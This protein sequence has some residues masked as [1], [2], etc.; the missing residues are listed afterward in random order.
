M[1][2]R[3]FL[4][5]SSSLTRLN[6]IHNTPHRTTARTIT[7]TMSNLADNQPSA[8]SQVISDTAKQEGGPS[9]GKSIHHHLPIDPST[10]ITTT[11]TPP[12]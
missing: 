5:L 12:D 11:T 3:R 4:K 10:S 6:N 9:K 7:T 8:A 2:A 1:A